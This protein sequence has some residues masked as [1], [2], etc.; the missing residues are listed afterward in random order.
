M[1]TPVSVLAGA[2]TS[3]DASSGEPE[4]E[5]GNGHGR[6]AHSAVTVQVMTRPLPVQGLPPPGSGS[7]CAVCQVPSA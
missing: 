5:S 3:G 7:T 4:P 2:W 1:V 6:S